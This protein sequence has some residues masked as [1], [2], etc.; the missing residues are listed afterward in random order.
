MTSTD[1]TFLALL[2]ACSFTA[3]ADG[4]PSL[5]NG[6]GGGAAGGSGGS[7]G[8]GGGGDPGGG[9]GALDGGLGGDDGQPPAW[10]GEPIEA[11]P[12]EWTWIDFPDT[13]CADGS[14]TGLAVNLSPSPNPSG[15]FVFIEPGGAC[16]DYEGC[17]SG[18]AV[19]L[20][21]FGQEEWD[22]S[23]GDIYK[24]I[25]PMQRDRMENPFRDAHQVFIPYCTADVLGGDRVTELVN[26]GG[27]KTRTMHY[28]GHHNVAEFLERLVPTFHDTPRVWL[29]GSS[30]GGFGAELNWFQFAERFG[31]VRVDVISDSGQPIMPPE[32]TWATWLEVWGLVLPEG[33]DAC[34]EGVTQTLE[35][36][37]ATLLSNGARYGLITY[38]KDQVI[39]TFL[40]LSTAEHEAEVLELLA[41]LDDP[42]YPNSDRADYFALSGYA[43]TTFISQFTTAES[44]DM[45][46]WEWVTQFVNDDP[47]L[48]SVG[49]D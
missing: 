5:P 16:W 40:G 34:T 44:E 31:D 18:V 6:A 4:V 7:S 48:R 39:G 2:L 12:G 28:R 11:T 49:P 20:D 13:F 1:R 8:S 33:C 21:G 15:V 14:P 45:K 19:H 30:A 22:G 38:D 43:H 46:V 26:N 32:E 29:T 41:D 9:M 17:A 27:T 25:V 37:A 10:W 42:A 3:C 47:A 36:G 23:W 35:H 24:G